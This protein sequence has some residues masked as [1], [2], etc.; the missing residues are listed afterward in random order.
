MDNFELIE[1]EVHKFHFERNEAF[2]E[3]QMEVNVSAG[4]SIPKD[5]NFPNPTIT[6]RLKI[7]NDD[8]KLKM[9]VEMFLLYRNL[10][11]IETSVENVRL[12]CL[13]SALS[14][15]QAICDPFF[16]L[17]GEDIT[18]HELKNQSL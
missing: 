8:T 18:L 9:N 15:M 7:G 14:E 5:D 11:N 13:K 12:Y 4:V 2:E 17:I 3:K 16:E 10:G 1:K 6:L